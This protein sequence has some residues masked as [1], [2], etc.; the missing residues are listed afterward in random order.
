MTPTPDVPGA[1]PVCAAEHPEYGRCFIDA[2]HANEPGGQGYHENENGSWP[3]SPVASGTPDPKENSMS[4]L[5]NWSEGDTGLFRH[6]E[7][8]DIEVEVERVYRDGPAAPALGIEFAG[9]W[10]AIVDPAKVRKLP[11]ES[12]GGGR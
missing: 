1:A 6:D 5:D 2:E 9:D 7:L 8:G 3:A 11:T 12:T 4:S 10:H